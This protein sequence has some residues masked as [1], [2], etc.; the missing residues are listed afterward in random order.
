[1]PRTALWLLFFC[2][3]HVSAILRMAQYPPFEEQVGLIDRQGFQCPEATETLCPAGDVCCPD[4]AA[5]YTSNGVPLC[6]EPCPVV[7]VTCSENGIL[8]CCRVGEECSPSGCI[9]GSGPDTTITDS[10]GATT[11]GPEPPTSPT[12]P[13]AA[14]TSFGCGT[15]SACYQGISTWCCSP[16]LQCYLLSPGACLEPSTSSQPAPT[17]TKA[18]STTNVVTL[19]TSHAVATGLAAPNVLAEGILMKIWTC[20]AAMGVALGL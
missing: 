1:M 11:Q 18:P 5:C 17:T 7:A 12:P 13:G 10:S 19:S 2:S 8:A 20:F 14:S 9:P 6:N 15:D 4:G 3:T 16:P